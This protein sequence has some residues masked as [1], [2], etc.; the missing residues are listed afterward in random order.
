MGYTTY[1]LGAGASAKAIPTYFSKKNNFT[2]K[3]IEFIY[4]FIGSNLE[5]KIVNDNTFLLIVQIREEC[6]KH[7]TIDTYARKLYLSNTKINK[8]KLRILKLLLSN[9]LEYWQTPKTN[10]NQF[11]VVDYRYDVL[12]STILE[13][14]ELNPILQN[15]IRFIS[16]NYDNQL[17]MALLNFNDANWNIDKIMEKYQYYPRNLKMQLDESE[18]KI[19]KLNGLAGKYIQV[20]SK[21]NIILNLDKEVGEKNIINRLQIGLSTM[22]TTEYLINFAWEYETNEISKNAVNYAKA[23]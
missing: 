1:L 12:L 9:F 20:K 2:K 10:Q 23:F 6:P 4:E 14:S 18:Q 17:E 11:D 13:K 15:D 22:E 7:Y 21:K 16:W 8:I 19:V 5:N 3:F